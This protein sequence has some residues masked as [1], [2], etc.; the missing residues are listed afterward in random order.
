MSN[1]N[2]EDDIVVTDEDLLWCP[3]CR[4]EQVL[5]NNHPRLVH[6]IGGYRV[7]CPHCLAEGP[8]T[9]TAE[10]AVSSWLDHVPKGLAGYYL[11]IDHFIHR[12]TRYPFD[13]DPLTDEQ[14]ATLLRCM[15]FATKGR[16]NPRQVEA[17]I[18]L[19][20]DKLTQCP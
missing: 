18:R 9:G 7:C 10:D 11:R 15:M 14:V 6:T 17:D 19:V 12:H 20:Y 16:Y 2:S 4:N 3:F 1:T 5:F 13:I 8:L